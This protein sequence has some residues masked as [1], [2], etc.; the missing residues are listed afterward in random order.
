M[1]NTCQANCALSREQYL[2]LLEICQKKNITVHKAIK[3]AVLTF[4]KLPITDPKKHNS[5]DLKQKI[6]ELKK[7]MAS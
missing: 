6:A 1:P 2:A 5:M 4:Y 3:T 7:E